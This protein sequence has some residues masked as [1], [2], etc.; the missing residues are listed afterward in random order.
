MLKIQRKQYKFFFTI[1][2]INIFYF[3]LSSAD[4]IK[5]STN[6]KPKEVVIIQLSALMKN[7][8][9]YKDSGITQTWEFAHPNNQ[10]VTGPIERF[11]NMIKTDSYSMLLNHSEHEVVEVYMSSK[12]ATFEVTVLDIEK[13]YYKF[14]WQVEKYIA[15]GPL[16]DCWLTTAVSQ[17]VAIGSSI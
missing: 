10:R 15:E 2:F 14:R 16:K 9:P 13:K 12:M 7:D 1:I 8:E 3:N 17:P 5:P 4:I 11:K 6:I